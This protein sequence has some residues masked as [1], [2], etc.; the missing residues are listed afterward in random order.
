[1]EKRIETVV[2]LI[3]FLSLL[4][5]AWDLSL[6]HHLSGKRPTVPASC[7]VAFSPSFYTAMALAARDDKQARKSQQYLSVTL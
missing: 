5:T 3:M 4:A 2:N 7:A 6:V 1:M